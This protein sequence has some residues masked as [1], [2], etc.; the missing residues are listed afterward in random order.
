MFPLPA[1]RTKDAGNS[2]YVTYSC[3]VSE[4]YF[5]LQGQ[6]LITLLLQF[7]VTF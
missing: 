5:L 2:N 6:I 4:V 1:V 3:E 7:R